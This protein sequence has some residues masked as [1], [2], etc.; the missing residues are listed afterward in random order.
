MLYWYAVI[1]TSAQSVKFEDHTCKNTCPI[2]NNQCHLPDLLSG[3]WFS[4]LVIFIFHTL[5]NSICKSN[6]YFST[7]S[8]TR[9]FIFVTST[10]QNLLKIE[11]DFKFCHFWICGR[12]SVTLP[13]RSFNQNHQPSYCIVL[14]VLLRVKSVFI[15]DA[16]ISTA[17]YSSTHNSSCS[18]H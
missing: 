4:I 3:L 6:H 17:N 5:K 13:E 2:N 12:N 15:H 18:Q 16:P 9:F 1:D 10:S 11:R 8:F 7:C 14:D